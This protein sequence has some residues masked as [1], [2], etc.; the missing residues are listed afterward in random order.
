MS[1]LAWVIE[2]LEGLR[3]R[4]KGLFALLGQCR[5]VLSSGLDSTRLCALRRRLV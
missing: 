4:L 1:G 3:P 5:N 2:P